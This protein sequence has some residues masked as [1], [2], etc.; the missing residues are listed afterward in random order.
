VSKPLVSLA[1]CTLNRALLL[2]DTLRSF[3]EAHRPPDAPCELLVVDNGSSDTTAEVTRHWAANSALPLRYVL[4]NDQGLSR[5]RNRAVR[6]A[7]GD[8]IWFVDDDVYFSTGWWTG[9]VE[10]L[11]LFPDAAVLAGRVVPVFDAP[12]PAWLPSSALPYY[13]LTALGDEPRLLEAT[14]YPVG[15]NVAFRKSVFDGVGEFRPDLGRIGDTLLSSEETDLVDRIRARDH[16]VAYAPRA[17]VQHRVGAERLTMSWLRRR[18]YWGGIS[19][20]LT[21]GASYGSGRMRLVRQAARRAWNVTRGVLAMN[22]NGDDQ[23]EYARLLG[24]ARQ[25]LVQ[26]LRG[27]AAQSDS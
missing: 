3:A 5:A 12:R 24:A 1:I 2:G 9:V 15:A 27:Q 23:L 7:A 8:W 16:A 4:E 19:Y 26:A 20:V 11:N 14:E 21:D 6:E 25:Y 22:V 13:G 10:A 17:E 18:A